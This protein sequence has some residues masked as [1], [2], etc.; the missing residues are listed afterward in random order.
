MTWADGINENLWGSRSANV[1]IGC[2]TD[3]LVRTVI[4]D[5]KKDDEVRNNK[6]IAKYLRGSKGTSGDQMVP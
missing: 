1:I 5:S 4:M 6:W 2:P 3:H